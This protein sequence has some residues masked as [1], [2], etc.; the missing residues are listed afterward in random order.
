MT[1][2][3]RVLSSSKHWVHNMRVYAIREGDWDDEGPVTRHI[4]LD[5]IYCITMPNKTLHGGHGFYIH[6]QMADKP[7]FIGSMYRCAGDDVVRINGL[8]QDV[9]IAWQVGAKNENT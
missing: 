9:L 1:V 3:Q 7:M 8:Y 2:V 5:R 6:F 4:D